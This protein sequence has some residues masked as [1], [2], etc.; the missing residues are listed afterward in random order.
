MDIYSELLA[1]TIATNGH[2]L[3]T[4]TSV[5][6]GAS[7]GVTELFLTNPSTDR[8]AYCI[9]EE[10]IKHVSAARRAELE[11]QLPP[12][13]RDARMRG[14]PQMGTGS[15]FPLTL[16][17]DA[18]KRIDRGAEYDGVNGIPSDAR[19]IVG[20]DF[21]YDIRSRPSTAAGRHLRISFSYLIPLR[22]RAPL[23]ASTLTASLR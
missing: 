18:V 21:G 12:H 15:V 23:C 9:A 19:L 8:A 22:C 3:L 16:V 20:I 17:N 1:R 4:Y 10:D 11:E 5:G 13:E 2:I 6:E 14:V 7:A